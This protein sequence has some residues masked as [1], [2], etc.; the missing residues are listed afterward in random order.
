M[1]VVERNLERAGGAAAVPA[2]AARD[3]ER[4]DP[5]GPQPHLSLLAGPHTL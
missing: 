2:T 4:D 5:I 3:M 1:G